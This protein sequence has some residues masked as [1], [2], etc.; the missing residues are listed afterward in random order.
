MAQ[1][2]IPGYE[3]HEQLGRGG[4]AT[5]YRARHLN[6][7]R[8][9][10]IK[11]I[12]TDRVADESFA[13]R[14]VREARI[15][16]R[17]SHP[18]ILQIYDVNIHGSLNYISMELLLGGNLE[19][20]IR[21]AMTQSTIYRVMQQITTALDYAARQGYVHRDIK[22]GNI[23][24][25]GPEDFVLTD[26]GIA[27]AADSSTQMTQAG[28]LVGT[29][30]YMS[31]E[32]AEGGPLDGRSDLYSLAVVC[33]EMLTKEVPFNADS[34]VSVAVKH[35][36]EK[37]PR[38][39][40]HL[41]AYQPFL[42]RGLAKKPE[43]RFQ[44]GREMYQAFCEVRDQFS[45]EAV[46]TAPR[47]GA[48][49]GDHPTPPMST[50]LIGNDTALWNLSDDNEPAFGDGET[51]GDN[52][53]PPT[54][55]D[56]GLMTG[57]RTEPRGEPTR[58]RGGGGGGRAIALGILLLL[59][60]GGGA[61]YYWQ[62]QPGAG[63]A[64]P[65]IAATE[66]ANQTPQRAP[67]TAQQQQSDQEHQREPQ[68]QVNDEKI[69]GLLADGKTLAQGGDLAAAGNKYTTAL[70][71]D[72]DSTELKQQLGQTVDALAARAES[73]IA[74]GQFDAAGA[75]LTSALTLAPDDE[76]LAARKA[77]LPQLRSDWQREQALA[78]ARET[79]D[80]GAFDHA[81][82]QYRDILADAPDNTDAAEGLQSSIDGLVKQA[83]ED[84]DQHR[85]DA[86]GDKLAAAQKW[87]PDHSGAAELAQQLPGLEQAWKDEQAAIARRE[88][89]ANERANAAL[90]AMAQGDLRAA[91][92]RYDILVNTY[93][94]MP[95]TRDVRKRLLGAYADEVKGRIENKS[96]DQ[97]L[98]L[99]DEGEVIA[100][101]LAVWADLREEVNYQETN[102][103]RR[104]GAY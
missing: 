86:A 77:E 64:P 98:R 75:D 53:Q 2:N 102:D 13:E 95:V 44:S 83:R 87:L 57:I 76:E 36:T 69:A 41:A 19:E 97:A 62:I 59:V 42:D 51:R 6:L 35:L 89:D 25:R 23:M 28:L 22:P 47:P 7:D 52:H 10:A 24:M 17:L 67:A 100:P 8:E 49:R 74:D 85:F 81:A 68:K 63:T 54:T 70:R 92:Q 45:D 101:E 58:R 55:P 48:A 40:R 1:I 50:Q 33:Y 12:D 14:F 29:P 78:S 65:P 73:A 37:I 31:P 4:M 71:L 39:P 20:V 5:V 11:V 60:A 80:Q 94:D 34:A 30:S 18:H 103:R 88:N 66:E 38:L 27:R 32:Q 43:H 9:V 16:A 46:L 99:I 56:D 104:L 96:Y 72:P 15:S 91:R 93:P 3:I 26:F 79:L 82:S 61:Y 21:G 84:I 90:R